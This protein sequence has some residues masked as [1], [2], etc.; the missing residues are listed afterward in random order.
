MDQKPDRAQDTNFPWSPSTLS[1][2]ASTQM[3]QD[4]N[5]EDSQLLSQSFLQPAQPQ[6]SER[7][8]AEW[9]EV[10]ASSREMEDEA[11]GGHWG[12]K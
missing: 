3:S 5:P 9:R 10:G 8:M 11:G 12:A 4:C 6:L 7:T 2:I 1:F